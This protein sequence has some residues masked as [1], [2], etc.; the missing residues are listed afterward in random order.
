MTRVKGQLSFVRSGVERSFARKPRSGPSFLEQLRQGLSLSRHWQSISGILS[1][2]GLLGAFKRIVQSYAFRLPASLVYLLYWICKELLRWLAGPLWRL[3]LHVARK[4][5]AWPHRVA[6]RI[7]TSLTD[8]RGE[9]R[10]GIDPWSEFLFDTAQSQVAN[11]YLKFAAKL[12]ATGW[13]LPARICFD[14]AAL[15]LIPA[16]A[17]QLYTG[18]TE[19]ALRVARL[20][21]LT[22]RPWIK[23]RNGLLCRLYLETLSRTA[24]L[25]M[26]SKEFGKFEILPDFGLNRL[27][28]IGHLY[29]FKPE[30]AKFYLDRAKDIN[31]QDYVTFRTSGMVHLSEGN[32][33]DA[34]ADFAQ[35]VK[36][37]PYSVM[38]H[39]N[40][41]GRYDVAS[42]LPPKWEVE[43]AGKLLIYDNYCILAENLFLQGQFSKSFFYYQK[44]LSYQTELARKFKLP[45]PLQKA[46]SEKFPEYDRHLPTRLLPWEWIIQFGH[47]GLLDSYRKMSLLGFYPKANYVVLAPPD[48]VPNKAFLDH[49]QD[50]FVIVDDPE[51]VMKLFPYQRYVG[52]NF[53]A[54]PGTGDLAEPWTRAAARAQIAWAKKRRKPLISLPKDKIASGEELLAKLGIPEGA[55]YVGLHVREGGYYLEGQGGMSEHRNSSVEDYFPAIKEITERGMWV[56]RLGDASMKPLSPMQN[57]VDY[58]HSDHKSQN[59]DMFLLATSHFVIGTT[60][61]LTTACLSFGT[62]MLL[63][64]CISNDWQ[65]WTANTDFIFKRIYNRIE[66]RYLPLHECFT[67]PVQ[68]YLINN[69][70]L[71]RHGLET[72]P[73]SPDEILDAVRYKLDVLDGSVNRAGEKNLLIA[74][75]RRAMANNPEM[76]GA[77]RPVPAYLERHADILL[78][79]APKRGRMS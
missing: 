78:Q 35:S 3:S 57:V 72:V 8:S 15:V 17:S 11:R 51:L 65:L 20:T 2:I 56:I 70:V 67:Q 39:Q 14:M 24:Q 62:Q 66:Q 10:F 19:R 13:Q 41:A 34:A 27:I 32:E 18:K 47:I 43:R 4:M 21:N 6:A 22:F 68:G 74:A 37:A 31:S 1:K 40:Y 48:K 69:I 75:Y 49:W 79:P 58:A 12:S 45:G 36:L 76:F 5:R 77:A 7:Y 71:D 50:H 63:T 30:H 53:M 42:Y 33:K 23:A 9:L 44:M 52:D 73:N 61:G 54:Y 55:R 60:S 46:L 64:N 16:L 28:G 26:I 29:S 25:E 59:A 38:A